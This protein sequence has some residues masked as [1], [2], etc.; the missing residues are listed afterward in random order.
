MRRPKVKLDNLLAFITVAAKRNVDDA[1]KE[2]GL[3]ASGVRKQLDTIENTFG[4]RLFDKIRGS[5]ILTEEGEQFHEDAEKAVEQALLVEE[6]VY[7]RRAI[8]NHHL[9]FGHS[10]N[11]P[12]R[13]IAAI[14]QPY[15]GHA[16][17]A[18]RTPKWPDIDHGARGGRWVASCRLWHSAEPWPERHQ[19][20]ED[21]FADFGV[22]MGTIR[23]LIWS[24]WPLR[25]IM[26]LSRG[27]TLRCE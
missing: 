25:T 4:I 3:S 2:L 16:V 8:R 24:C 12:P 17:G 27:Q 10:T 21:H 5:L 26:K 19:K 9:M 20:I 11:L 22:G 6:H 15:R 7:A 18:Y 1:A 13:L 23:R 14:M